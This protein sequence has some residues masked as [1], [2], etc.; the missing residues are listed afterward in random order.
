MKYAII[1]VSLFCAALIGIAVFLSVGSKSTPQARVIPMNTAYEARVA[2]SGWVKGATD[3]EVTIVEFGDFQCPGCA[4]MSPIL[5][6]VM[7]SVGEYTQ[8]RFRNYPLP[9]HNKAKLAASAAESAG[10]QGKYWEMHDILYA[11]QG[12]WENMSISDFQAQ[13]KIYGNSLALN[14]QQFQQDIDDQSTVDEINKDI[15]AGN[16]VPLEATPTFIVNGQV[17]KGIP[18]TAAE[19]IALVESAR[20]T[21]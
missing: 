6:E 9:Q 12:V 8:L 2:A 4:K 19:F 14:M 20:A 10:R 18:G 3:P 11:E 21:K 5:D 1:A 15:T 17:L 13:L 7:R 16:A